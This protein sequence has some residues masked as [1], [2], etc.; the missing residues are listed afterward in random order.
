[1]AL[2][3]KDTAYQVAKLLTQPGLKYCSPG[4][5]FGRSE[6]GKTPGGSNSGS[7]G[8]CRVAQYSGRHGRL[9]REMDVTRCWKVF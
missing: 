5:F 4:E 1:M 6:D 9:D 2:D 7:S 8:F 3:E